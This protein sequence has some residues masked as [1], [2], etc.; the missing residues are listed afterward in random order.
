MTQSNQ[1][2]GSA[3]S[4]GGDRDDSRLGEVTILLRRW[5]EGDEAAIDELLPLVYDRLREIAS[6]YLARERPGHTLQG[7]ALVHEAYLRMAQIQALD[8]TDRI[9]FYALASRTMR[10]ILVDHARRQMADMRVGAHRKMPLEEGRLLAGD[11][12]DTVIEIHEVLDEFKKRYPR[13]G[14]LVELRFFGG[15]SEDQAAEVLEVSRST[16][17][18]DWRFSRLWLFERLESG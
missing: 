12:P 9:H 7:T 17:A 5:K 3:G 13:Q 6:A 1:P 4:E 14:E 11:S 8:T 15:L 18:R 2:I 16:V 10:R